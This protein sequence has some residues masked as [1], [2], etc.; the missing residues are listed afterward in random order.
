[1]S[2]NLKES[3]LSEYKRGIRIKSIAESIYNQRQSDEASK[4]KVDKNYPKEKVSKKAV[5]AEVES[6]ILEDY[7]KTQKAN[8]A[9]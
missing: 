5:Q 9:L 8:K 3:V 2:I 7:L 1:V 4:K 6:I